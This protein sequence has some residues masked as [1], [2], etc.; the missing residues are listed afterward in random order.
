MNHLREFSF[1][2]CK[3]A[4]YMDDLTWEEIRLWK[5][6]LKFEGMDDAFSVKDFFNEKW[7]GFGYEMRVTRWTWVCG[8]GTATLIDINNW[9]NE[10]EYGAVFMNGKVLFRNYGG[11][12]MVASTP[13]F[14]ANRVFAMEEIHNRPCLKDFPHDRCKQTEQAFSRA[15]D[16]F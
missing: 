10:K 1:E 16:V 15:V 12:F 2:G 8:R 6:W 9:L 3:I 13:E 11:N 7:R 4:K 14:W 5:N